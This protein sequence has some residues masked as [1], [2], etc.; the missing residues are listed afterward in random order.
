MF[1]LLW[2]STIAFSASAAPL[3]TFAIETEGG[4]IIATQDIPPVFFGEYVPLSNSSTPGALSL[5][6]GRG[7]VSHYWSIKRESRKKFTWG[8]VVKDGKIDSETITPANVKYKPY[9]QMRLILQYEDGT[10][11]AMRMY[12]AESEQFGM[13]VVIGRFVKAKTKK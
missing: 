6:K 3:K 11:E 8:V 9:T 10:L 4:T 12:R 13:R 5:K 1:L 7:F 2:L